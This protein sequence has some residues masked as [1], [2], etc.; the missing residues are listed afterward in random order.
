MTRDSHRC[1][2]PGDTSRT[3]TYACAPTASAGCALTVVINRTL[4]PVEEPDSTTEGAGASVEEE[5]EL[6]ENATDSSPLRYLASPPESTPPLVVSTSLQVLPFSELAW[7]DFERLCYRLCRRYGDIEDCLFYGTGGQAQFGIDIFMWRKEGGY[8]VVQCKRY[9]EFTG[10]H[11]K[12]AVDKFLDGRWKDRADRFVLAT[13][14]DL[15][16]IAEDVAAQVDRLKKLDI[17]FESWD[18]SSLSD[19]LKQEPDLVLDFFG[20]AAVEVFLDPVAME[21]LA[22]RLEPGELIEYRRALGDL[23]REV[24]A[25]DDPGIVAG[26]PTTPLQQRFVMPDLVIESDG[27]RTAEAKAAS[28][29]SLGNLSLLREGS[30]GEWEAVATTDPLA[31]TVEAKVAADEW[32][33]TGDRKLLVGEPGAGKSALLRYLLLD[34]FEAE[35]HLG[36]VARRWGDAVPVWIPFGFWTRL[37]RT[38]GEPIGLEQCIRSWLAYWSREDLWTLVERAIDDHRLVL[39]VDGLDEWAT[40]PLGAQAAR[41]LVVFANSRRCPVVASSRPFGV[42]S[43]PLS[44]NDWDLG[45][46]AALSDE[47]RY[48]FVDRWLER[49]WS[50]DATTPRETV[51]ETLIAEVDAS[52]RIRQ[53]SRNPLMLSIVLYLRA[54]NEELAT[55]WATVL[56]QVVRHLIDEHRRQKMYAAASAAVMPRSEDVRRLA[57]LL[58]AQLQRRG[59]DALSY[60]EALDL[61]RRG[62]A[63]DGERLGL[64]YSESQAADLARGLLDSVSTDLGLFVQPRDGSVGFIHRFIQE[65]LC[66][67]H[68]LLSSAEERRAVVLEKF[69]D[70]QWRETITLC[71]QRLEDE[72]E[73]QAIFDD[74]DSSGLMFGEVV[75]Q[76]AA[77]VSFADI[78]P[79]STEFRRSLARRVVERIET[80]ERPTHRLQLVGHLPA[81]LRSPLRGD[82]L[83]KLNEWVWGVRKHPMLADYGALAE[84]PVDELSERALWRGLLTDDHSIQRVCAV[85]LGDHH[86]PD[87]DALPRRL[88]GLAQSTNLVGRRAAAVEALGRGWPDTPDLEDLIRHSMNSGSPELVGAAVGADLRRGSATETNRDLLLD[89]AEVDHHGFAWPSQAGECLAPYFAGDGVVLD[90]YLRAVRDP[91]SRT[92]VGIPPAVYV[93]LRGFAGDPEVREWAIAQIRTAEYPFIIGSAWPWHLVATAYKDDP[94]VVQAVADWAERDDSGG[95]D[96]ELSAAARV[97]R[98]DRLRQRLLRDLEES[99]VPSWAAGALLATYD[100]DPELRRSLRAQALDAEPSRSQQI[101]EMIPEVVDV[102]EAIDRLRGLATDPEVTRLDRVVNGLASLA[103][104]GDAE[105]DAAIEHTVDRIVDREVDNSGGGRTSAEFALFANFGHRQSV[106]ALAVR[107]LGER[108]VPLQALVYGFRGD[109]EIRT[110][111]VPRLF[112]LPAIVRARITQVL[113]DVPLSDQDV[114]KLLDG[115][116]ADADDTVKLLGAVGAA[117]RARRS[118][119]GMEDLIERFVAMTMSVGHDHDERRLAGFAGLATLGAVDRI[120]DLRERFRPDDPVRIQAPLIDRGGIFDRVVAANWG[121]IRDAFGGDAE[122]RLSRYGAGSLWRG[123]FAVAADYAQL[124]AEALKRIDLDP[125]TPRRGDLDSW[126]AA[127]AEARFLARVEPGSDRLRQRCISLVEGGIGLSYAETLPFWQATE[128]LAAQFRDDPTVRDWLDSHLDRERSRLADRSSRGRGPLRRWHFDPVVVAACRVCPEDERLQHLASLID[129]ADGLSTEEV[130]LLFA[131][132][133]PDA[134]LRLV[135]RVASRLAWSGWFADLLTRPAVAR[136]GAD[137]VLAVA[138]DAHLVAS[139]D[140]PQGTLIR[141]MAGAGRFVSDPDLVEARRTHLWRCNPRL[142]SYDPVTGEMRGEDLI[143][144][145]LAP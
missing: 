26:S 51:P 93:L 75:D 87:S 40:E 133:E 60:Q 127:V 105:V 44:T 145:D 91:Q 88:V 142:L 16:G 63:D 70:L 62:L 59:L 33:A 69:K 25:V 134:F 121:A 90:A 124:R 30:V 52:E 132:S 22:S 126:D 55:D 54:Q 118:Q 123:L 10:H 102:D 17:A 66:A 137:D 74:L 95:R 11:L 81:A 96:M 29:P 97:G 94:E 64:G 23:Y 119:V 6:L 68:L 9:A 120:V 83:R 56:D 65:Y 129:T 85:V 12:K 104:S 2:T 1:R 82:L 143:W 122:D 48:D 42:E 47:Q 32:L 139:D 21:R 53:L 112:P 89:L 67:E 111:L 76:L 24:V 49:W 108:D 19:M 106:R 80:G 15:A 35:P 72:T 101:A 117:T 27:T 144:R 140:R 4:K 34:M 115:F 141:L 116:D 37:A 36:A 86:D 43:L 79:L 58:A 103:R 46:I 114:T 14:S 138:V 131:V 98:S 13:S 3:G 45:R 28:T 38:T 18:R 107:R 136:L 113:T 128:I 31:P 77:A 110:A 7:P 125:V 135:D 100:D 5:W 8:S 57:V 39:L 41:Q 99:S 130:E 84:W 71:L 61:L 50:R 20:R 92:S 109:V 73:V 78:N